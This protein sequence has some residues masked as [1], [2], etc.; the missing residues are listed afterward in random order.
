VVTPL[1]QLNP[2]AMEAA[3]ASATATP[4]SPLDG[5]Q[6]GDVIAARVLAR[7][8]N[9]RVQLL[10]GNTIIEATA[11]VPLPLG[12]TVQ[13]AVQ[14]AGTATTLQ[15]VGQTAPQAPA[16]NV[17]A[18]DVAPAA[19]NA[20]PPGAAAPQTAAAPSGAPTA[21]PP[22]AP[23]PAVAIAVPAANNAPNGPGPPP[24]GTVPVALV[25]TTTAVSDATALAAP[26]EL[27]LTSAQPAD[28]GVA[29]QAAV[30][31]AAATQGSL[32]P[33]FSEIAAAMNL[34]ALPEPVQREAMR[35]LS[36][37]PQLDGN[38]S[39]GDVKQAFANSG[40]FLEA[41]LAESA[42]PSTNALA[43]SSAAARTGV[44][45][46]TAETA[47][48]AMAAAT[49]A[50]LPQ[51]D[52]KAALIVFRQ[53]LATALAQGEGQGAAATTTA[54]PTAVATPPPSPKAAGAA[55]TPA[56][57]AAA[58][59]TPP[60]YR[61]GPTSAQ[62][63]AVATI[64]AATPPHEAVRTLMAATDG[65]LARQTL[66]QAASLPSQPG[67]PNHIDSTG[68][69]WHFEVPFATPQGTNV[70]QFEISRD[71]R[72][73][74]RADAVAPAWQARFSV[75]VDPIGPVHAQIALRGAHAAVTLWAE[76][77]EGAAR[78]RAGAAR[79]TDALRAADLDAGDLVVRD[80]APRARA[81][82][83]GHFLDRAL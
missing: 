38:L 8:E 75:D 2:A 20:A 33:L 23:P 50:A 13:L 77:P 69:R 7:L 47:G 11:Q 32:A 36:L 54:V 4:A 78:L 10:I 41:Q 48:A 44:A 6:P 24:S 58:A 45:S 14:T 72:A 55:S 82:P 71:G 53:V 28:P 62:P 25:G 68:P 57:R 73:A 70:A 52:L 35:L 19:Q 43:G 31:T 80:G 63:P 21:P 22:A 12:A 42:Q 67:G 51:G 30:R 34:P 9:S 74:K 1:T 76:R 5:L 61:D 65:A 37:R 46:N 49:I 18:Q 79:L 66:L 17:A 64:D 3:A 81:V 56:P 29:L 59:P 15:F 26:P 39:A 60:P 27:A 83:A 40:L 16:Q